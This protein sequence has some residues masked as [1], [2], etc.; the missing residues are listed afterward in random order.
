MKKQAGTTASKTL[1]SGSSG[2]PL[3]LSDELYY[4]L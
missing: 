3:V 2:S 4:F 1:R